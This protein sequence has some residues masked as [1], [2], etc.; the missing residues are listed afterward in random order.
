LRLVKVLNLLKT[1]DFFD[2]FSRVE[3][4]EAGPASSSELG[5]MKVSPRCKVELVVESRR[6]EPTPL[7]TLPGRDAERTGVVSRDEERE[8]L[9]RDDED[10][11]E[12]MLRKNDITR[13]SMVIFALFFSV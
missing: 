13:G 8:L 4:F 7:I 2:F 11:E 9:A 1:L 10:R 5:I 3:V 6:C 12:R